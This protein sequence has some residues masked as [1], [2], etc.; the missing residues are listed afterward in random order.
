MAVA[1]LRLYEPQCALLEHMCVGNCT[2]KE[3]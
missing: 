1:K 3:L 2:E